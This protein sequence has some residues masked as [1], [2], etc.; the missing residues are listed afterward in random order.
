MPGGNTRSVLH[1]MPFPLCMQRGNE[2]RLVDL[3]GNEYIDCLGDMTAGLF[4]HSRSV[5]MKTVISTMDS[6]GMNIGSSTVAEARFAE[7]I[8][9]RFTSIDQVRFCNSGTEANIY[10]LSVAR[11]ITGRSKVIV[12]EGGYHGGVLSFAHGV[13]PN[14]VDRDDWILGQYNDVEGVVNLITENKDV[15]AA[16]LVE[17]MQGAGGC[18]PGSADFLHAIQDTAKENGIIFILDEV[19]TSRLAPGGLQSI[20]RHPV[21]VTPLSPDMTTLGKWI[22]GGLSIGAFGGRR[23]LMSVYDPRTSNIHHSGTF[24]NNSLAMNVGCTGMTSVYTAEACTALNT[25]GDDLRRGLQEL[26]KGTNMVVTGIGA[27]MNI[28]FVPKGGQNAIG[29]ISDLEVEPRSVEATLRDL[30]WFYL[31]E[32]GF[33]IARRGMVSLLL[34]TS[35]EEVEALQGAVGDFLEEFRDLVAI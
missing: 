25:L 21:H 16:V 20:V 29:R 30:L 22:G 4:G 34:G 32:R 24:N 15:A 11:Q 35:S 10:A 14:N 12:F 18:I 19:M 5:I 8:C 6:V 28:H 17:G 7:A 33:W 23:D 27:V 2:N 13:A 9:N 26:A 31:I 1:A 3:D